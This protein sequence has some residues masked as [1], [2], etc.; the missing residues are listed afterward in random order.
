MRGDHS[1]EANVWLDKIEWRPTASVPGSST[2]IKGPLSPDELRDKL[3][4]LE[5]IRRTAKV[6]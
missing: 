3:A 6:S 4:V 5:G 1:K 2:A